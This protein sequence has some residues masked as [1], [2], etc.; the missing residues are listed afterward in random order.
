M[1]A[2]PTAADVEHF[3]AFGFVVLRGAFDAAPL[4]DE[5]ERAIDEAS[6]KTLGTGVARVQ[7]APMMTE[8][9][10]RSLS[11]VDGF[12]AAA[13]ALLD[14]P[15]IPLRAKGVRYFGGTAWHA[16]SSDAAVLSVGFAAYL[17]PLA[18]DT[19]ALRLVPGSHRGDFQAAVLRYLE[20]DDASRIDALPAVAIA[21]RPGDVIAFDE[22]VVHASAGGTLRRQ[23][24]IDYV[25]DPQTPDEEGAVRDYIARVFSV[26]VEC[27]YD[28]DVCPSYG[29][30][31]LGSQ[32]R[33]V[34]RLGQLGAYRCAEAH[35]RA[36][37]SRRARTDQHR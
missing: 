23:W 21:T 32:R 19:G 14:G 33:A 7:Y 26:E 2:V 1:S 18:A 36:A 9:N 5:L 28:P 12:E 17:E 20:L 8:R 3:R 6:T 29:A 25:R 34:A 37:R 16:D 15:V 35:E 10:P 13:A 4:R 24:R 11:L 30:A 31:W 22:H 27:A